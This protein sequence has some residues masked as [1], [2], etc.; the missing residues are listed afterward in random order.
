MIET[1]SNALQQVLAFASIPFLVYLIREKKVFGFMAYVG[2]KRS[3]KEA[4]RYALL[5][6]LVLA[7]TMFIAMTIDKGFIEV[8]HDPKSV[9][10]NLRLMGF[11]VESIYTL[12]VI[13]IVKTSF[14]EE[15]FFRGFVA[16]R[17][18]AITNYQTGNLIQA[19]IFGAIHAVL[20]I[21]ITDN[22]LFLIIIFVIPTIGAYVKVYLN[23]KL[24]NG[25]IIP[26]WIAHATA[27]LLAYSLIAFVL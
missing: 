4:N 16:K 18:I 2:L 10:G 21:F 13:A 17:L 23:E 11:G 6:M 5:L 25:S 12:L 22:I 27:N 26:G 1:I 19:F 7:S 20:F 15:L 14:A 24:A 9:T 8:L 3:S